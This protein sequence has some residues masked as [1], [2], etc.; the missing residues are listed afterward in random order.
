MSMHIGFVGLLELAVCQDVLISP[1]KIWFDKRRLWWDFNKKIYLYKNV[2]DR[3]RTT[4]HDKMREK[5]LAKGE[6]DYK[7]K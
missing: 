6:D 2:Q 7:Q 4:N 5:M 3:Q 1:D